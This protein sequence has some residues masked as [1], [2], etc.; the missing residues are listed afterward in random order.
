MPN[1][2]ISIEKSKS[3]TTF[4]LEKTII[5]KGGK[6]FSSFLSTW[7]STTK[8]MRHKDLQ[9]GKTF[10][11]RYNHL[12]II[13]TLLLP[14]NWDQ[15]YNRIHIWNSMYNHYLIPLCL[16]LSTMQSDLHPKEN[17]INRSTHHNY[18][19][20]IYQQSNPRKRNLHA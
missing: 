12:I 19:K 4:L 16:F 3:G 1:C 14:T 18:Y 17:N 10:H 20:H 7:P 9:N 11:T 6:S 15:G 2:P 8:S 5:L 13:I